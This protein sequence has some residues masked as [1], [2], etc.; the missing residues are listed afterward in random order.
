MNTATEERPTRCEWCEAPVTDKPSR[1]CK[2]CRLVEAE[3]DRIWSTPD[4]S[5]AWLDRHSGLR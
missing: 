5:Y 4:T 2:R 1:L 3:Q